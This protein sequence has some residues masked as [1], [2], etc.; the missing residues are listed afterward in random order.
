MAIVM[1]AASWSYPQDEDIKKIE[2]YFNMDLQGLLKMEMTT[3]GKKKEKIA[4]IPASVVLLTREEIEIHGYRT[5]TE[6]LE[7]IPG[8]YMV[9]DYQFLAT[10]VRGFWT[11]D[12]NRNIIIMVNGVPY[13]HEFFASYYLESIAVP[14]EA[15]DRIEVVR[16]PVSVVY[17]SGGFFGAIDIIIDQPAQ[18]ENSSQ[19]ALAL[20]TQKTEKL[21][22]RAAGKERAF[23]YVFNGSYSYTQGIDAP[24]NQ[25]ASS[26]DILTD[27]GL[28]P[29]HTT[30]GQ[31]E[32]AVKFF[33][34]SGSSRDF[35]VQAGYIENHKET[36]LIIPSFSDGTLSRFRN[37][38]L[39]V[40]YKKQLSAAFDVEAKLD[41]FSN[42][43]SYRFD[44]MAEDFYGWQEEGASGFRAELNLFIT[45]SPRLSITV[46][47]NHLQVLDVFSEYTVPSFRYNLVHDRLADGESMI[48]RSIFT[49]VDYSLSNRLKIVAGVMFEQMPPYTM[50]Q[51]IGD[52][53]AGTASTT[54]FTY[55]DTRVEFIPRLALIYSPNDRNIFKF[56]Y[57]QGI[58][59]PS[60]FHNRDYL[61]TP[62][63]SPLKPETIQTLELNYIAQLSRRLTLNL[64]LFRNVLDKL[65]YRTVCTIGDSLFHRYA[66]VGELV[67]HGAELTLAASPFQGLTVEISGSYQDTKDK[68]S[69]YGDREVGYSPKF[70]GYLKASYFFNK[71]IS[72]A[73]TGNYVDDME[74]YW[75]PTLPAPGRLG[76]R[77]DG[78]FLLGANLRIHRL[79]GAPA[80]LNLRASN[81]TDEA[82][83][84]PATAWNHQF[85]G[86]GTIGRGRT[87][88]LTLGWKF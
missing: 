9:N 12:P 72:L 56:L 74:A 29:G 52:Y 14:V 18:K 55:D 68:R 63:I 54:R 67:T 50:E 13:R 83:R 61:D 57:G 34:F 37:L 44:W 79:F 15:I 8:L 77:V 23:Q 3:A 27:N 22:L 33:N 10:G 88:L 5:L 73:I 41:Y 78:Y 66:N 6:I 48:A 62:G 4:D 39:Q 43:E 11:F 86:R 16:G 59:R 7:N 47:G 80:F 21:F 75:D 32:E 28:S 1:I 49:Q 45:P 53:V 64:S 36:M 31:L 60:M 85:A 20:G 65:I 30:G 24:M 81:L 38:R 25:M 19:L 2:K 69:G 70:L 46:G 84:F 82:V 17:G 51:K 76:E 26:P 40:K 87:L 58:N 71:T 42:R 35:S